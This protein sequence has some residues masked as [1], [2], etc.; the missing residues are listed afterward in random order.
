[1]HDNYNSQE[2]RL[3]SPLERYAVPIALMTGVS[4]KQAGCAESSFA[5]LLHLS[6]LNASVIAYV[7]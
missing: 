1:M 5:L 2:D 7:F 6:A 4:I 3:T